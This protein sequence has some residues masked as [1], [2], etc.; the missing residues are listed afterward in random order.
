MLKLQDG[1][2]KLYSPK[3]EKRNESHFEA[4]SKTNAKMEELFWMR[5]NVELNSID[6]LR[7]YKASLVCLE[8]GGAS[9][10]V[11]DVNEQTESLI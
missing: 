11:V 1:S 3:K 9:T 5:T 4:K 10:V 6:E 2:S 7:G 8:E